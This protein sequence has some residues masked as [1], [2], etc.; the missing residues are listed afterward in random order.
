MSFA[1][2][3][4]C[5]KVFLAKGPFWAVISLFPSAPRLMRRFEI[6]EAAARPLT[7]LL[8]NDRIIDLVVVDQ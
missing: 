5:S 2:K 4:Q 8:Q 7:D 1:G 3:G 6:E